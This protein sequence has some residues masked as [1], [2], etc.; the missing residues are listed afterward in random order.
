MAIGRISGPLLKSNLIRDG[1]DLAF[2][3]D[4]LYLDVTNRRI[5]VNTAS[6]D[7]DLDVNGTLRATNIQIDN[8]LDVGQIS[9]FGNN[10][11]SS[12]NVIN[13]TAAAGEPTVYHSLLV[14]DDFDIQ[15]N[16]I[17]TNKS[18]SPIEIR[19]NGTG[20]IELQA[21]TNI[22]GNLG[23]S[24]NVTAVGNVVIG[25]NVTIGNEITDSI[26][27][28]ASIQSDLIPQADN[29]FDLGSPGFRW[30]SVYVADFYTTSL[31]V[32]E[33]D[34]GE[35][36]FRDNEISTAPGE[37]LYIDGNGSGGVRLGNFRI[38][39]NIITN[40][41]SGSITTIQQSGTGYFKIATTNG[42]VPPVGTN[43]QR[44]TAYAVVGMTRYNTESK[45]LEVWDGL[46]WASPSGS[47]GAVSE[48]DAN[49]IAASFALILG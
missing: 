7:T 12:S 41:V 14:V 42:F 2:E 15:N 49:D 17:T 24:G 13:F 8:Q 10:I 5:G 22:T 31:N 18:N 46:A 19:P 40:L 37:D 25:G 38:V 32:P 39:D 30:R 35:I 36:S 45:A 9:I 4:L 16:S 29:T 47:S 43:A 26:T 48:N 6:P 1:V 20:T 21:N 23:V 27:I 11:N 44:P 34:V 33:L 28:N 3:T